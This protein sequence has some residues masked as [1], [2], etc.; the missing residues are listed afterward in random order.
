MKKLFVL[1]VMLALFIACSETKPKI[2]TKLPKHKVAEFH[3]NNEG[4]GLGNDG[5]VTASNGHSYIVVDNLHPRMNI[6]H[7]DD[8]KKCHIK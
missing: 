1:T 4:L 8:C 3:L 2:Q 6:L 7:D 5:I